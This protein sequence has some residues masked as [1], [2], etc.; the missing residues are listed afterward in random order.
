MSRAIMDENWTGNSTFSTVALTAAGRLRTLILRAL[1]SVLILGAIFT[2]LSRRVG[3]DSGALVGGLWRGVWAS[4]LLLFLSLIFDAVIAWR[5]TDPDSFEEWPDSYLADNGLLSTTP[6]WI[7]IGLAL[8]TISLAIHT[9][10]AWQK[11]RFGGSIPLK[12]RFQTV[13]DAPEDGLMRFDFGWIL[14]LA[15]RGTMWIVLLGA[16]AAFCVNHEIMRERF[17]FDIR[18]AG[19]ALM[20]FALFVSLIL[21]IEAWRAKPRRRMALRL[22]VRLISQSLLGFFVASSV[23]FALVSFA[24]LPLAFRFERNFQSAIERGEVKIARARLGL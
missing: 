8:I 19:A 9:A 18:Y 12:T 15:A 16:F 20:S 6:S 23:L 24:L 13:F 7:T 2:W 10:I 17:G 21:H 5:E 3:D 14:G 11:R 22:G 1:P 4:T